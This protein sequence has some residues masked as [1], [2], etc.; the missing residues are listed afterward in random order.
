MVSAVVLGVE[1]VLA[2]TLFGSAILKSVGESRLRYSSTA[3]AALVHQL[4]PSCRRCISASLGLTIGVEIS[5]GVL[6]VVTRAAYALMVAAALFI[7]MAGV[8]KMSLRLAPQK[9]CGCVGHLSESSTKP[10]RE[11]LRPIALSA[12]S[13]ACAYIAGRPVWLPDH[14]GNGNSLTAGVIA[15]FVCA[16]LIVAVSPELHLGTIE[17]K[18]RVVF[19]PRTA[20]SDVR[21]IRSSYAWRTLSPHLVDDTPVDEWLDGDWRF[22]QWTA[23]TDGIVGFVIFAVLRTPRNTRVHGTYLESVDGDSAPRV[24]ARVNG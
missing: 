4:M 15:F 17:E 8:L 16:T 13:V 7:A 2:I 11:V 22:V 3:P 5:V 1:L 18:L 12:V 10:H 24:L 21:L 23:R 6:L 20:A 14:G 19:R 9:P